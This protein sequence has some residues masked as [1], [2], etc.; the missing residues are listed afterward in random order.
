VKSE[1]KLLAPTKSSLRTLAR[2]NRVT[3]RG[4]KEILRYLY[5][6]TRAVVCV[7]CGNESNT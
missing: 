4:K 3:K 1:E 2:A 7:T 6:E 5:R